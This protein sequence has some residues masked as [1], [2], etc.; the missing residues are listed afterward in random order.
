MHLSPATDWPMREQTRPREMTWMIEVPTK[1]RFCVRYAAV[2]LCLIAQREETWEKGAHRGLSNVERAKQ[3][4]IRDRQ[5]EHVLEL[6][7]DR[8][9]VTGF[10][11]ACSFACDLNLEKSPP[12]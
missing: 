5:A 9:L 12:V 1:S 10:S 2:E 11:A 4:H 6:N 7:D 3:R 8:I